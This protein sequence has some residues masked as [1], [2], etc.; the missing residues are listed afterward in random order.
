[1]QL[2]ALSFVVV[3]ATGCH[4]TQ[5][6]AISFDVPLL[7]TDPQKATGGIKQD[8]NKVFFVHVAEFNPPLSPL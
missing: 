4:L 2:V 3:Q 1:M 7:L 5:I 6:A 8:Q